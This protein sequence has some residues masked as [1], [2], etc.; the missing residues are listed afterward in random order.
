MTCI[1]VCRCCFYLV[2]VDLVPQSNKFFTVEFAGDW[3]LFE[4]QHQGGKLGV[5][6]GLLNKL[7]NVQRTSR[8][9]NKK[10]RNIRN[11]IHPSVPPCCGRHRW[12]SRRILSLLKEKRKKK[13]KQLSSQQ[14]SSLIPQSS[15]CRKTSSDRSLWL[16]SSG[17]FPCKNHQS[18]KQSRQMLNPPNLLG[19]GHWGAPGAVQHPLP[20]TEIKLN[21]RVKGCTHTICTHT[22]RGICILYFILISCTGLEMIQCI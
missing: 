2:R 13:Q 21:H 19:S 18:I 3:C 20:H 14:E 4:M 22:L 5:W 16:D 7:I 15:I 10:N 17:F 8:T 11:R 6:G 12:R 9:S 1:D